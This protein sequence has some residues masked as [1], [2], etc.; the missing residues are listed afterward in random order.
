MPTSVSMTKG[1]S[2]YTISGSSDGRYIDAGGT[3]TFMYVPSNH[4][5]R[6]ETMSGFCTP[7]IQSWTARINTGD[8]YS[9][10]YWYY[11]TV[12]YSLTNCGQGAVLRFQC[13]YHGYMGGGVPYLTTDAAC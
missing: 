8:S 5:M 3:Y 12:V 1:V 10:S 9:P 7:V 6:L 2:G 4:P 11:G 13:G